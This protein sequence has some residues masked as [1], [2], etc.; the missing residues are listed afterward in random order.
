MRAAL[1]F[2]ALALLALAACAKTDDPGYQGWVEAD[3]IFVSPDEAGRVETLSVREG[4]TVEKGAPLFTV[5][6]DLQ[7]ADVEMAKASVTNAHPG[8]R[9]RADA[10]QDRGRHAE[11][12]SRTRKPRCAP[13]RRGSPRRRPGWRAARLQ[14]GDR[15]A[16]SRSTTGRANW[17]RPAGRW[18]RCCRRAT[19]R[20]ASS[21]RRRCCRSVALGE[22]VTIHCDG[23]KADVPAKVTLHLPHLRIHAAGDLQPRRALQARVPDRG[24]HRDAG[25]ACASAS[26]S[27]VRFAEARK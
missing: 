19:S 24:A 7:Q 17:C 22:A 21:C 8:V 3:L 16:C 13:R 11:D 12:A 4:D 5:D 6:P 27:D 1:P 10:A 9:A 20:S 23:C 18:C 25:R 14:P 2:S 15:H 26:R